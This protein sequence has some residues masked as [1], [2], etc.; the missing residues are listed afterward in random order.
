MDAPPSADDL[1]GL[2][3]RLAPKVYP[4]KGSFISCII[5]KIS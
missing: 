2:L 5:Y 4:R 1:L 3:H